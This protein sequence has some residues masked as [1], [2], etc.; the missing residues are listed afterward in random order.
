MILSDPEL[1]DVSD[2]GF[3]PA[4]ELLHKGTV[5]KTVAF[6]SRTFSNSE[7]KVLLTDKCLPLFGLLLNE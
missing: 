3:R 7:N 6:E 4:C 2:H 1:T 5:E